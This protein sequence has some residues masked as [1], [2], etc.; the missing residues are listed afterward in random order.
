MQIQSSR[1]NA[2]G[3]YSFEL[4]GRRDPTEL[5]TFFLSLSFDQRRSYFGG[6]LS[7]VAIAEFCETIDWTHTRVIAG[8]T[9]DRLNGLAVL[10]YTPPNFDW[11]ELSMVYSGD[12]NRQRV[13]SDL[14]DLAMALAPPR[15]LVS[16]LREFAMPELIQLIRERGIGTFLAD[17]IRIPVHLMK[18]LSAI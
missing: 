12:C 16:I 7:D 2:L 17:E 9:H 3:G 1:L 18:E 10:A 14:F 6:S 15:C 11:A 8:H 13:V 4:L 5:K